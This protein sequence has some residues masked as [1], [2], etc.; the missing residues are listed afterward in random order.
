MAYNHLNLPTNINANGAVSTHTYSGNGEKLKKSV[1]GSATLNNEYISGI[2]YEGGVL[3]FVN[4]GEGRVRRTGTNTYKYEYLLTDHLGN[5]R[6]YFEID[7]SNAAVKI[8]ELDYYPFGKE[9]DRLVPS[10]KNLYT[11]NGKEKQEHEK[12]LD[13][14]AR[15]Y[16]PVIGRW[17]VIDPM[18]DKMRR[19]S[20]YNYAFDNP[21]RF[22]DPDGMMPYDWVWG[23][24][25]KMR[26]RDDVTS[27]D[28]VDLKEGERYA[29]K[30]AEGT[31]K[32]GYT[33]K[34]NADGTIR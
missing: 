1:S 13:Y 9:I 20:P 11:Y 2:H 27:E 21:V 29:G 26:W 7:G 33:Y 23:A 5:G 16:D 34:F 4:T 25:N 24:D 6:V 28:D 18:A 19:H 17:H 30:T 32:E 3:Q 12:L 14:G 15:F 31:T 8:Q 22:I 10:P